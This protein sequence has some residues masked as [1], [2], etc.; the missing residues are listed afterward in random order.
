[1]HEAVV[2][3]LETQLFGNITARHLTERVL[4]T[5]PVFLAWIFLVV[6]ASVLVV[7]H[8]AVVRRTL[9]GFLAIFV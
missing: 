1:M 9:L 8:G 7:E 3:L 5:K 2:V 4:E 6:G